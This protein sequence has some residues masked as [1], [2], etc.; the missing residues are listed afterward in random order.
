MTPSPTPVPTS[1]TA[2]SSIPSRQPVVPLGEA[3]RVRFLK[4]R[5]RRARAAFARSTAGSVAVGRS[6]RSARARRDPAVVH[7]SRQAEPKPERG[8]PGFAINFPRGCFER[9]EQFGIGRGSRD[10]PTARRAARRRAPRRH[11]AVPGVDGDAE[12]LRRGRRE[13]E[14][15]A[16]RPR[17]SSGASASSSK[18]ARS[19]DAT[20]F[21]TVG[22]L[23]PLA[24]ATSARD[25]GP[26][27]CNKRSTCRSFNLPTS[28]RANG[29]KA[30][31][32]SQARW[33]HA[34]QRRAAWH[35]L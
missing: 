31:L 5:A 19:N 35:C 23:R 29:G 16:G 4:Q 3:Q 17:A 2:K 26:R 9:G 34:E 8:T 33:D 11:L 7:E 14:L 18:P 27:V 25:S 1:S 6:A 20:A 32:G 30:W 15:G 21:E 24:R 22:A 10:D 12:H 28:R 13:P